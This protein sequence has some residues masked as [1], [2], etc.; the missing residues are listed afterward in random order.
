VT[1]PKELQVIGGQRGRR[2]V[3]KTL[4]LPFIC[5]G[6]SNAVEMAAASAENTIGKKVCCHSTSLCVLPP[7]SEPL[8]HKKSKGKDIPV[9]GHGGP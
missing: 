6:K 5:G 2:D 4:L 8:D 3:T 7:H 1:S 9:T